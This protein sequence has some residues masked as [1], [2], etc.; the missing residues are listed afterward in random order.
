MGQPN[1]NSFFFY[2]ACTSKDIFLNFTA[3]MKRIEVNLIFALVYTYCQ[4]QIFHKAIK[5]N[6]FTDGLKFQRIF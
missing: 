2:I 4:S 5:S 6:E 3:F 1:L